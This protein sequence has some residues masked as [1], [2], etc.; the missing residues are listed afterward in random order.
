MCA[1]ARFGQSLGLEMVATAVGTAEQLQAARLANCTS[2]QGRH[3]CGPLSAEMALNL[4]AGEDGKADDEED[5]MRR[6]LA[7]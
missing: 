7:S 1:A 2:G 4:V 6:K 3:I 5:T